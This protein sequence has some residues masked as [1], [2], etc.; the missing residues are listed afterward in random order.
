MAFP[1]AVSS[2]E[3]H[4]T[5]ISWVVL[6]GPF[7]YKIKK[8]VNL[9]FVD[10]TSLSRRQFFCEEELRLNRRLAADLYLDVLPICGT[11]QSPRIGGTGPPL[12]WCVRMRQFD[13][14]CLLTRIADRG[15][16]GPTEIDALARQIAEFHAKVPVAPPET[17]YGTP[18]SV[19]EPIGA[20]FEHLDHLNSAAELE[21]AQRLRDWCQHELK[22]LQRRLTR[23]QKRW[24]HSRVPRR[25]AS[26]QHD[27]RTRR[28]HHF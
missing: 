13:Q 14:E 22:R 11:E 20:N 23:P 21:R 17:P 6:T 3:L 24:L 28:H 10:F 27:S 4:E 2:I 16:L 15:L 26:G 18:A 1:H 5:H 12:E 8:P 7:A 25:H 9:G 19:A